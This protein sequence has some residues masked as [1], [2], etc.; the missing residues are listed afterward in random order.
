M[1]VQVL[2]LIL[3]A[4]QNATKFH[5]PQTLRSGS[6]DQVK[7]KRIP[8]LE[9]STWFQIGIVEKGLFSGR[10]ASEVI[11]VDPAGNMHVL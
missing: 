10:M 3:S 2:R 6:T 9:N 7:L 1:I 8:C 11:S 4:S 5:L